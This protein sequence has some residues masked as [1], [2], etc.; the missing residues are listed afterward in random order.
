MGSRGGAMGGCSLGVTRS[1]GSITAAGGS[2]LSVMRSCGSMAQL[3]KQRTCMSTNSTDTTGC[4]SSSS[5]SS[6]TPTGTSAHSAHHNHH[7]AL[8]VETS[9]LS[10][11]SLGAGGGRALAPSSRLVQQQDVSTGKIG[12]LF[13]R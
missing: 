4:S 9:A 12:S 6:S 5:G 2:S 7:H 8:M 10:A 1:S 3:L 13:K 11:S